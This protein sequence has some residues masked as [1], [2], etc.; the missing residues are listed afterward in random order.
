[1]KKIY[2]LLVTMLLCGASVSRAAVI[3]VT[4]TEDVADNFDGYEVYRLYNFVDWTVNGG[5][6]GDWS[7]AASSNY[8]T[9]DNV[10]MVQVLSEGMTNFY[11]QSNDLRPRLDAGNTYGLYD[12]GSGPRRFA[13]ADMKAGQIVVIQ[14]GQNQTYS[15][16]DAA[17]INVTDVQD[18]TEEVH[19]AQV[20]AGGEADGLR[21][22]KMLNDAYF[23]FTVIRA[24][25]V[26]A[27]AILQDASAAEFVSAPSAKIMTVEGT[28]RRLSV[29]SGESSKGN[30]CSTWYSVDG[31]D[32]LFLED[33]D[34]IA[35]ADTIWAENGV[36]YELENVVY[37][38]R[39]IKNGDSWGNFEY[40]GDDIRVSDADDEDGDGFV[41]LK[42]ATVSDET[43]I[44][45]SIV[46]VLV[47]VNEI[48]L[49][50]PWLTLVDM[51]GE[52]R[53]Y[54]IGW[55]SNLITDVPHSFYALWDGGDGEAADLV[56]GDVVW[57]T[58]DVTVRVDAEGYTSSTLYYSDIAEQG[59]AYERKNHDAE[60]DWDFVHLDSDLILRLQGALVEYYYTEDADGSVT[61]YYDEEEAP[62]DA[63]IFYKNYGWWYDASHSRA[64][65]QVETTDEGLVY[66]KDQSGLL[67]GLNVNC[68]INDNG[69]S[70]IGI[71]TNEAGLYLMNNSSINIPSVRLGEYAIFSTSNGSVVVRCDDAWEGLTASLPR[72]TYVYS[73]DIFTTSNPDDLPDA[74][75]DVRRTECARG[76][77]DL[78][79]RRVVS[80]VLPR[81]LYI[82]DG[83][84]VLVR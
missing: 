64:W 2:F 60:H 66:V 5:T 56:D 3:A 82:V 81:G 70:C 77:Y 13:I 47:A 29:T 58:T 69:N 80:A 61:K 72:Y 44:A 45:S 17:P 83:R 76:V 1:M 63:L 27:V 75:A 24:C 30:T 26:S 12:F 23:Q 41:E 9:D 14:G 51:D 79:G 21:Y 37:V 49:N 78:Q 31:T 50:E 20:A 54:Q 68:P 22:Y 10:G 15:W 46:T 67:E 55:T 18:L 59:V 74:I 35:S 4:L 39:A 57:A 11:V 7:L 32:P 71:Y 19:A 52:K 16:D 84:K 38:Q 25:Y 34:V 53:A 43:G 42:L 40:D 6:L 73:I 65:L 48:V 28:A 36:D 8:K 33:T 62:E